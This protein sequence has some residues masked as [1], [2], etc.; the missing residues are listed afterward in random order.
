MINN[1]PNNKT[2][3]L[4]SF[5]GEFYQSFKEEIIPVLLKLFQK[6][7]T[8]GKL[9]NSFY[10][11]NI[12]LICKPG[13]DPIKKENYRPITLTKWYSSLGCKGGST[14]ANRSGS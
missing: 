5:P 3:G 14:F 7:E 13:K 4:D 2:P 12:T 6:I 9:P 1:V 11:A 10:E 8:K